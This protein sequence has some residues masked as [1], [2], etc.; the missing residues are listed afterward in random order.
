MGYEPP[1]VEER[2]QPADRRG[3]VGR[4]A[5]DR[6]QFIRTAAAAALAVCG[7]LVVVFIFFWALGA[8]DIKD[9]AA[10]TIATVVFALIWLAGFLFRSRQEGYA[11]AQRTDRERRGF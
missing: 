3:S 10:A 6:T 4:R 9:A 1:V 11:L 8:V 5:E 7:G 2:R